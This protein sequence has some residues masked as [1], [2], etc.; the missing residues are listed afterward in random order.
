MAL[1]LL[2][3]L[4][5][6]RTEQ[7]ELLPVI[8]QVFGR[9][10]ILVVFRLNILLTFTLELVDQFLR[11]RCSARRSQATGTRKKEPQKIQDHDK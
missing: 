6:T 7:L 5:A 11:R 3:L 1:L 8:R 4:Q 9:L 2:W 10:G